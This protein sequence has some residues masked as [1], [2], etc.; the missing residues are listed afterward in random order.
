MTELRLAASVR[1]GETPSADALAQARALIAEAEAFDGAPPVSDQALLEAS[2]GKRELLLFTAADAPPEPGGPDDAGEVSARDRA[3]PDALGIVGAGELDLVVRPGERG[4]GVGAAALGALLE[5]TSGEVRSWAHGVNPAAERLLTNAGFAPVRSLF[6]MALDPALLSGAAADP[7][8]IPVPEGLALRAFDPDST[9]DA[10]AWVDA[11]AAAFA[12]H[13]EQGRITLNDF[14]A[15]R[16]EPWFDPADLILLGELD[17]EGRE[18]PRIAGSTWVK[19]VRD[20]A[21]TETELYA[22]GVRPDRAG[23]GLGRILLAVTLSRMAQHS[24]QRVTL[25]VDGENSRAVELYE[26]AGFTVDSRSR[27]WSRSV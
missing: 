12:Q 21:S 13:P 27:Q 1:L 8:A 5:R 19:T 3:L 6:R 16:A 25:Y 22:V 24:P 14:A 7:L 23:Q 17:D 26:R 11:N 15:M 4:R 18:L 10:S 9:V 20:G 2:Q